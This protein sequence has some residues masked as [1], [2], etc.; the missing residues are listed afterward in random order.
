MELIVQV[1]SREALD[2]ALEAGVAGVT[3]NLPR[4]PD[5]A[6]WAGVKDWQAAARARQVK[7]YLQWDWLVLEEELAQA[8]EALAALATLSPDALVLRDLGLCR[9]ARLRHPGLNLHAAGGTGFHNSP[10]LR[11]AE[12]MGFSRVVVEGPIHLKDLGLLRRQSALPLEVV[13]PHP[14][15]GFGHL[16]LLD[17]YLGAGCP[18]CC[19][20]GRW[21]P[22]PAASLL[23]ALEMLPG[24]S[25]VGVA[26]VQ[27]GGV[28]SQGESLKR[29]IELCR[30]MWDTTPAGRPRVLAAA[31]EVLAAFGAEFRLEFPSEEAHPQKKP[32]VA[33]QKERRPMGSKERPRTPPG[34]SH[35]W[36]EARDYAEAIALAPVWREPL[37]LQLTPENYNAFLA[38]YRQW[39]RRRLVWRLPPVIRE[40]ALSFFQQAIATL[41]QG[42]FTR[43]VAGDWGGVAL[44]REAGGEIY[45]DQTLGVR[46]SLAVI[47]ARDLAVSRVCLP[48]RG[49]Q[50]WEEMVKAAPRA[51]FWS[52]LYH[53]PALTTCPRGAEALPPRERG[54][55]GEKLRWLIEDDLALL[56]PET[57]QELGHLQDWFRQNGVSPLVV[58]LPHSGLPWGQVPTPSRPRPE[59]QGAGARGQVPGKRGC[60]EPRPRPQPRGRRRP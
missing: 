31:R 4:G 1:K 51:S 27:V 22:D 57:P 44:I 26:A 7:F 37:L 38:Q 48:G 41:K 5:E 42:G 11:L 28:F 49:P 60:P 24:L 16:C 40:S 17:D 18:L 15:P 34:P 39:D 43:F 2:A 12:T 33:A 14:C 10:G 13:L 36:L 46:N 35:I 21:H 19:R 59:R 55:G 45:G 52:Y 53:L 29:I 9:Q 20:P 56:C 6:W 25:Q 23:A 30:L 54:P 8:Q 47:A 58:S 50:A 32:A 3:V